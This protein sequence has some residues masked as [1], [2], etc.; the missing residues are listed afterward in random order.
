M[1]KVVIRGGSGGY[2]KFALAETF[3]VFSVARILSA[4]LFARSPVSAAKVFLSGKVE[5]GNMEVI[6]IQVTDR[7]KNI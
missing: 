7:K 4:E 5:S 6:V 3:V 1:A 2:E